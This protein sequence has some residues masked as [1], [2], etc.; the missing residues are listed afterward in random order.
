MLKKR[1]KNLRLTSMKNKIGSRQL[2]QGRVDAKVGVRA[3]LRELRFDCRILNKD[4]P[5]H[6]V[7]ISQLSSVGHAIE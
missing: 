2:N 6:I 4:G 1:Q 5:F 7:L 3:I